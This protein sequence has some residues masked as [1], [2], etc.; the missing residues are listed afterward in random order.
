MSYFRNK[1]L[2]RNGKYSV[3]FSNK[4][5]SAETK[6]MLYTKLRE[7][8]GVKRVYTRKSSIVCKLD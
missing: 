6:Q 4:T 5:F 1:V 7:E 2:I 3:L 8:C